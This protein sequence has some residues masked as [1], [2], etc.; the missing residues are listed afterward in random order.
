VSPAAWTRVAALVCAVAV[1]SALLPRA[2]AASSPDSV[3]ANA[4]R[5]FVAGGYDDRPYLGGVFG[6]IRV[7]G[8]VEG[9]GRWERAEGVT[10][11]LGFELTRLSLVTATDLRRRVQVW[12]ELEIE[13]GG[14]EIELEL[15][16]VDFRV[17]RALNLRGGVLLLPLGHF[18]LAHDGPR[19]ELPDRPALA[20]RLLGSAL[21]QPGLGVFGDSPIRS[22]RLAYE[23]YAVAGYDDRILA[24]E[25]TRL[26][27]GR[28]NFEDTNAS[29]AW[30]GRLEWRPT[31]RQALEISGYTGAYN[32][33]RMDGLDVDT[34][35]GV[36]AGV[37]DF[38]VQLAGM[39]WSGEF[40]LLEVDIPPGLLGI[41]ASGQSG[42]YI[43]ASRAFGS[44]WIGPGSSWTV[45]ARLDGIDLD[46]GIPGDSERAVTIG[47]NA[48]PI[49]ESCVK[50]AFQRAEARDRFNNRI[51]SATFSLGLA[52]YF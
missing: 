51:P 30:V 5:P 17:H 42:G 38:D 15:A 12:T 25:G 26:A 41:Y 45:V 24:A 2:S 34:R 18:N 33:F 47:I 43:E 1:A 49:P 4:P 3:G 16:Q 23:A 13:E 35:R 37:A 22:G 46:R 20:T 6:N 9:A 52:T 21:S 48:R 40:A 29:P 39:R 19:T 32:V 44:G 27:A 14:E 10:E 31:P 36:S 50:L 8:Y 7:G 11:E 28:R